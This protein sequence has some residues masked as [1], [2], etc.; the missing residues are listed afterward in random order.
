MYIFVYLCVHKQ[1][2]NIKIILYC[3]LSLKKK[4]LKATA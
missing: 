2:H 4:G 1:G 3:G